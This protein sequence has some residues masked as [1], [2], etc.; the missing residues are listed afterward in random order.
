MKRIDVVIR[1]VAQLLEFGPEDPADLGRAQAAWAYDLSRTEVELLENLAHG[2]TNSELAEKLGMAEENSVK[3]RLK[4][5]L[6]KV[7][8]KNR[9]QAAAIPFL[10]GFGRRQASGRKA[11]D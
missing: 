5:L 4:R 3:S 6:K 11:E 1:I 2:L 9:V 10:Y 7:G 8:A